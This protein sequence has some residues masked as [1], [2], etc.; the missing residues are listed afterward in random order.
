MA[1]QF[2]KEALMSFIDYAGSKGLLN[3]STATARKV[4]VKRITA[5]LE[6]H[7][8]E[9]VTKLDIDAI[10]HR[11][12]NME[13]SAFTPES[14]ATYRSRF[15]ASIDDFVNWKSNPMSF[16]STRVGS[17]RKQVRN[18]GKDERNISST[19]APEPV[20]ATSAPPQTH[21]LPVPLR[22]DLTVFIHGVPF[23]LSKAEARR[24]ANV[25]LAI[26]IEPEEAG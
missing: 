17:P 22:S 2:S 3:R 24:I 10:M 8:A 7:E 26:A 21:S 13:G 11:F 12:S 1:G 19:R 18:A 6:P 15:R 4:A 25:V 5:I 14:L 16:R 20:S 23:D 9:D